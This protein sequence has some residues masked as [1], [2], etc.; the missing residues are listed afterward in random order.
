MKRLI[1]LL[2]LVCGMANAQIDTVYYS[3]GFSMPCIINEIKDDKI[4]LSTNE[5]TQTTVLSGIKAIYVSDSNKNKAQI[6]AAFNNYSNPVKTVNS[7]PLKVDGY[8]KY[9]EVIK[10]DSTANKL[11]LYNRAKFL[12]TDIYKSAKDVIQ[13]DDKENGI[14]IVKGLFKQYWQSSILGGESINIYHTLTLS[15]KDGRY[16]YEITDFIVDYYVPGNAYASGY[17]LHQPLEVW[18]TSR[19]DN[20]NKFLIG[21]DVTVKDFINSIKIGMEKQYKPTDDW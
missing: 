4:I 9:F 3:V 10:L 16:K 12:I 6:I 2:C 15:A 13:L 8:Y 17:L 7:V 5:K 14:I 21:L 18:N 1:L 20:L 11:E 19:P